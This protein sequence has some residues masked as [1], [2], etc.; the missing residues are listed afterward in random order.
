MLELVLRR[1]GHCRQ[2]NT[3]WYD[4]RLLYER[5]IR[6]LVCSANADIV[7]ASFIRHSSSTL[8]WHAVYTI[9]EGPTFPSEKMRIFIST[10]LRRQL[11]QIQVHLTPFTIWSGFPFRCYDRTR[12]QIPYFCCCLSLFE[13]CK[14]YSHSQTKNLRHFINAVFAHCRYL[15]SPSN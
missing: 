10:N 4:I 13:T 2:Q 9:S 1:P 3:F 15:F 14:G 12:Q 5:R 6:F 7:Y 8:P 11:L